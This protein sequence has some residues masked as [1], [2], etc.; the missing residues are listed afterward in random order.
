MSV[1]SHF[2]NLDTDGTLSSNSD[3]IIPSQKAIKT[4]VDGKVQ[5]VNDATL[6]I[7]KNGTTVQ[8]F[9]ANA[10]SNVTANITVPTTVAELSDSSSYATKSDLGSYIPKD[11]GGTVDE[12]EITDSEVYGGWGVKRGIVRNINLKSAT[13]NMFYQADKGLVTNV[14]ATI[15][16]NYSDI[17]SYLGLS[18]VDGD[19]GGYRTNI[20]PSTMFTTKPFVWEMTCTAAFEYT[21]VTRLFIG[22]HTLD[23]SLNVTKYKLEVARYVSGEFVWGTVVD[24][25]GTSINLAQKLFGLYC[26]DLDTEHY[27]YHEIFG[28]RLTISESSET[29]FMLSEIELLQARGNYSIAPSLNSLDV[30]R[31]GKVVG[32]ITIPTEYGQFV[33]NL[34][35]TA[36]SATSATTATTAT[37]AGKVEATVATGSDLDIVKAT[38]GD[39]DYARVRVGGAT[40]AGYLE[41][42]TA[43]DGI[44]PIYVRQYTGE[45]ATVARTLTLLDSNGDTQFPGKISG[46]INGDNYIQWG[47]PNLQYNV[48]PADAGCIDDFGH[49]KAA[50]WRGAID[51]EY[52]TDGGNTWLDYGK[53]DAEKWQLVT[54]GGTRIAIGKE[55]VRADQGT[56]TNENCSNYK[57]RITLHAMGTDGSTKFYSAVRKLLLD[58]TTEGAGQ[59]FVTLETRTIGDFLNNVD[60]WTT[61]GTYPVSG[62]SGWNSIPLT[63]ALW[64]IGGYRDQIWQTADLRLTLSIGQ[65][66]TTFSCCASILSLRIIGVTNWDVDPFAATGYIYDFDK[67]KNVSFPNKV[68][69][70][71]GGFEGNL[72]GNATKDG[73]GNIISSTYVKKSGDTMTGALVAPQ[74]GTGM[75]ESSYFQTR[76]FR[77]QGDASHYQ[78]ALDFGYGGHD[79]WDFYEYGG[80]Y[81]FHKHTGADISTE[82]TILGTINSNGWEGNVKGNVTGDVTGTTT[83]ALQDVDGNPIKTTYLK[84]ADAPVV[85]NATLTITQGGTTKGTF[86]ANAGTDVTI[87]LD[88]GGSGSVAFDSISISENESDELQAIGLI[89]QNDTTTATQEWIGTKEEYDAIVTKD[90]NTRYIVTDEDETTTY[91]NDYHIGQIFQS[92][93]PITSYALHLLDGSLIS[94]EGMYEGFV[95]YVGSLYTDNPSAQYFSTEANWQT[96]VTNYGV[97]GKF[98]YTVA[99]GNNPATVRLPKYN[100]KIFSGGGNAPIIG[101][102]IGVGLTDGIDNMSI[103]LNSGKAITSNNQYGQA[104]GTDASGGPTNVGRVVGLTTSASNSG[105]IADLTQIT[106]SLDGYWYIVVANSYQTPTGI[107]ISKVASDLN[108]KADKDLANC[109]KPY[110]TETYQSGTSWYRVWSDGWCEQGGTTL[111]GAWTEITLLKP[112]KDTNYTVIAGSTDSDLDGSTCSCAINSKSATGF[113]IGNYYGGTAYSYSMWQ[114]SGYIA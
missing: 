64:S 9:T 60:N 108:G 86:T 105:M 80:K 114:A 78:H 21:D 51:I 39:N 13:K 22:T 2:L 68:S 96:A 76:K 34:A 99:S 112:Y 97:C 12:D 24:Y 31:G 38:V 46:C 23:G 1:K 69:A 11:L 37:T 93:L 103:S 67:D 27:N 106:T 107:Q 109:T 40:N 10:S 41:V 32:D 73:D 20:N 89:N 111:S 42:A 92:A 100:S 88:A 44:E 95:D 26:S 70:P 47:G 65:V 79:Q 56:L 14:K 71:N 7:Q 101:T 61:I 62:W 16:C 57:A 29:I 5:T 90:A 36:T 74:I 104:V 43:D 59:C 87:A 25:N 4:Y 52:T 84:A 94:G 18:L 75:E 30:G 15:T 48:S 58:F 85:N 49:N 102:G 45:F 81:V 53:T 19:Y 83:K 3:D 17:D 63:P 6:T 50:Y 110:V 82:D 113:Y 28:V 35:G 72:S 98:V 8:T 55:T 91:A 33:G 77:G 66:D 54:K